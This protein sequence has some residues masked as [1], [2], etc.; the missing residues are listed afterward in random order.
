MTADRNEIPFYCVKRPDNPLSADDK[1]DFS[2]NRNSK[3]ILFMYYL[4]SSALQYGPYP[5]VVGK[6]IQLVELP[7]FG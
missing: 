2:R 7:L 3:L 4:M 1:N 5:V 6:Q